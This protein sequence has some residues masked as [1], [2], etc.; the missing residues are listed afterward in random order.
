MRLRKPKGSLL[1]PS[2]RGFQHGSEIPSDYGG[3]IK[4]Y[5]SSSVIP[6][7]WVR[8]ECPED[9]NKPSGPTIEAVAHLSIENAKRLHAELGALLGVRC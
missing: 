4:T 2:S 6:H 7:I 9:L 5:Q 1:T 8:I 3:Y